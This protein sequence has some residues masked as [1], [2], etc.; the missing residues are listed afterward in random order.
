M[1][2][3]T[4]T[5][6]RALA[7]A[8]VACLL[9]PVPSL[10][11]NSAAPKSELRRIRRE[12]RQKRQAIKRA[13]RTAR[14]VLSDLDAT[15]RDIQKAR[16]ELAGQ[17]D[18]LEQAR[19]DLR[20]VEAERAKNEQS[21]AMLK[22]RYAKRLRAIYIMSRT[23]DASLF[24]APTL[25]DA[26]KRIDYLGMI[27]ERDQALLREYRDGIAQLAAREAEISRQQKDILR[28]KRSIEQ[29]KADLEAKRRRKATLLARV[30]REKGVYQQTLHDLE[31]A[32]TDLWA[33][34]KRSEEE[35]PTARSAGGPAITGRLPWPLR[36][37]VVTPFG[38]Q[39]HPRFGIMVY[40]RG[41]EIAAHDGE[42]VHAVDAGQVVFADWYTGYGELVVIDHGN[43]FYS[44]YGNLS[45]LD[46]KTDD[47]VAQGQVIGLT[48]DTGGLKG[49]NLYFEIRQNGK[50]QDPL[51]RLVKR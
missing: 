41:I 28:R 15:D 9:V 4:G 21:L 18:Q 20:S 7:A 38:L 14:S 6:A 1:A 36:G 22:R 30:R 51:T 45:R 31:K 10:A 39:R 47:R 42:P 11:G 23:G 43:G 33:R 37:R 29:D 35:R 32:S 44:L 5:F 19:A 16:G 12:M 3:G 48:G 50:A 26:I 40:R 46:V 24:A 49:S 8:L 34:I 2:E 25:V 13:D 17:Q 27:A